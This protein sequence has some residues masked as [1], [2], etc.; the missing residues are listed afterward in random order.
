MAKFSKTRVV[1]SSLDR[2]LA[3]RGFE[4]KMVRG[5]FETLARKDAKLFAAVAA[6]TLAMTL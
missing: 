1:S 5:L 2:R 4:P 3:D 6:D